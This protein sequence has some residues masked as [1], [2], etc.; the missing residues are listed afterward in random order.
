MDYQCINSEEKDY[1]E[2]IHHAEPQMNSE[3][4]NSN[5]LTLATVN[6]FA[7]I[8]T[9]QRNPWKWKNNIALWYILVINYLAYISIFMTYFICCKLCFNKKISEMRKISKNP[10]A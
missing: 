1:E 8:T 2:K 7:I 4:H 6:H 10:S 5:S 3:K 9:K